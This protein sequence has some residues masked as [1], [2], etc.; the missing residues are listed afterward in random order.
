MRHTPAV[1]GSD[2]LTL[3]ASCHGIKTLP[4][5]E[6]ITSYE[7]GT[8]D[9]NVTGAVP[10]TLTVE[11]CTVDVYLDSWP[12]GVTSEQYRDCVAMRL[13]DSLE[14]LLAA[15]WDK[16]PWEMGINVS[17]K[18]IFLSVANSSTCCSYTPHY[19]MIILEQH[20]NS[21]ERVAIALLTHNRINSASG[22][23]PICEFPAGYPPLFRH[24]ATGALYNWELSRWNEPSV[25]RLDVSCLALS[26]DEPWWKS[27][28][29]LET[30]T[31]T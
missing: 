2:S 28:T 5:R 14:V 24:T 31:L 10:Q 29:G 16:A 20:G 22:D 13:N 4:G 1:S 3:L 12:D 30:I 17:L 15:T 26:P 23:E 8:A 6:D 7:F 9:Y 25:E 27:C 21:W 18:G 11:A 19:A